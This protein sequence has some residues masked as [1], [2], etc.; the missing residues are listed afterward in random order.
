[1]VFGCGGGGPYGTSAPAALGFG[2][3]YRRRVAQSDS[4]VND[5]TD[6]KTRGPETVNLPTSRL[7]R[8]DI[9]HTFES[10]IGGP[11]WALSV[12]VGSMGS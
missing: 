8:N 3:R 5:A 6:R 2:L 10:L 11:C 9:E 1:M 12:L 7:I 4:R